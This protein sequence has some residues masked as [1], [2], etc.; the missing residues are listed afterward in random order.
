ML[1]LNAVFRDED[2]SMMFE[3]G[4][5]IMS[6]HCCIYGY[7]AIIIIISWT[8]S[9]SLMLSVAQRTCNATWWVKLTAVMK[10]EPIQGVQPHQEMT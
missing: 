4:L 1:P 2:I 7:D 5:N 3:E 9:L 10:P 6:H 8:E